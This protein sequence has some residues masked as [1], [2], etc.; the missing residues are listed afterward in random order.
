[1]AV[2]YWTMGFASRDREKVSTPWF[3]LLWDLFYHDE[4]EFNANEGHR[5][6]RRQ[7]QLV[8]ELG[9][10][11]P[12]N[13]RGAARPSRNAPHILTG[14]FNHAIDFDNAARVVAAAHRR[15]VILYRPIPTEPWH[16]VPERS[17]MLRYYRKNRR[18]V[19]KER[20]KRFRQRKL[21]RLK[22]KKRKKR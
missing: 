17:T 5:T 10:W 16:V 21:A 15:G 8:N 18:R 7:Q 9:V 11:S 14:Y 4:V 6:M 12:S 20:L 13:P 1:M 22:R 2:K 19:F 3:V